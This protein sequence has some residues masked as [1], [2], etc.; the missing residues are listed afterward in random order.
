MGFIIDY[1]GKA[2]ASDLQTI[3]KN[4]Y[5]LEYYG[6][7]QDDESLEVGLLFCDKV[8]RHYVPKCCKVNEIL[9]IR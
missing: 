6:E 7:N 8:K 1:N 9:N 5:C 4:K 3:P 2:T